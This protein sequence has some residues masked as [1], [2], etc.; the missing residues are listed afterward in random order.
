MVWGKFT[1]L[2]LFSQTSL[3]QSSNVIYFLKP[4]FKLIIRR[5]GIILCPNYYIHSPQAAVM[6]PGIRKHC[7]LAHPRDLTLLLPP[8]ACW[9]SHSLP[10]GHPLHHLQLNHLLPNCIMTFSGTKNSS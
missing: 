9:T 7:A 10:L 8:S 1:Y 6:F 5:F 2:R 3:G 4:H